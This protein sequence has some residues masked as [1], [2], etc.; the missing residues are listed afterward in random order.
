[1]PTTENPNIPKGSIKRYERRRY[2][3][4]CCIQY[5]SNLK[6]N[7][8]MKIQGLNPSVMAKKKKKKQQTQQRNSKRKSPPDY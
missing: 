8:K 1:M 4:E 3:S 6:N 7:I 5:L 2:I